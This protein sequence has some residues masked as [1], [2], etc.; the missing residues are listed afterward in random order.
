MAMAV[1]T[2]GQGIL[3]FLRREL[4][5]CFVSSVVPSQVD[6]SPC[7]GVCRLDKLL[8][9]EGCGRTIQEIADWPFMGR[10]Q[11]ATVRH[12]AEVRLIERCQRFNDA[13]LTASSAS[14][15]P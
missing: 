14:Q 8:V 1:A 13:N 2:N 9:C 12:R 4:G 6:A 5:S 7:Q 11:R 15:T 10:S 3:R